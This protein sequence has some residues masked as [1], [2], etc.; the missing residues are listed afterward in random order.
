M[1]N[2]YKMSSL[3]ISA[4]SLKAKYLSYTL[5]PAV[6]ILIRAVRADDQVQ[7]YQVAAYVDRANERLQIVFASLEQNNH[8]RICAD[9]VKLS[10]HK[11][12]VK[13]WIW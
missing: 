11:L 1:E 12:M 7:G 8:W 13:N 3:S 4:F 6:T 5:N 10:D 9:G 2:Q